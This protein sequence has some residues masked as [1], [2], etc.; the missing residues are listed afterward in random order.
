MCSHLVTVP[1]GV[2]PSDVLVSSP[3]LH[4]EDSPMVTGGGGGAAGAGGDS[5][6]EY[7]GIDPSMDPELALVRTVP[8]S[9]IEWDC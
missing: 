3:V 2:L 4:G 5:F 7:G 1:A 6:A 8:C 9:T